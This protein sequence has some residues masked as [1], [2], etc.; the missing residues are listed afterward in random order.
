MTSVAKNL[1]SGLSEAARANTGQQNHRT[2]LSILFFLYGC[3]H[4]MAVAFVGS[5]ILA[6]A[7]EGY[8]DLVRDFKPSALL[9]LTLASVALPLLSGYSLLRNRPWA[10]GALSA[11]CLAILIVSIIVLRQLSWPR[12]S[13]ARIVFEILY[14]GASLAICIYG[15]WFVSRRRP[16]DV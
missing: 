15:F 9:V 2:V 7:D 16:I 10:R 12:L 6:L 13:T 5:V 1:E 11:T 3:L 8:V 4:L 14:G